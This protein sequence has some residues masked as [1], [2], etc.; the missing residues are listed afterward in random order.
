MP[1]FNSVATTINFGGAATLL[2][3][4]ATTGNVAVG[5]GVGTLTAGNVNS[6]YVTATNFSTANAVI[7]GGYAT[8]L[9]NITVATGGN[10]AGVGNIVGSSANTTITAGAYTSSFLS[11]GMVAIGGNLTVSGNNN[12]VVTKASFIGATGTAVTLDNISA[13]W[14]GGPAQFQIATVSGSILAH[15]NIQTSFN[16]TF[17]VSSNNGTLT[18]SPT[19]TGGT[20]ATAGDAITVMLTDITNG[21][22]YRIT[23]HIGP[24]YLNSPVIIERV[25]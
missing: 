3:I 12:N 5:S 7:S 9:A 2:T 18:T 17:T 14:N 19:N 23:G 22:F 25:V 10:I 16:G 21:R 13:N 1:L 24:S 15:W 6:G 8:G 4:G 11:N 20:A